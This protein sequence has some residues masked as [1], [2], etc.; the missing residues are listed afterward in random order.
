M[1]LEQ[2]LWNWKVIWNLDVDVVSSFVLYFDHFEAFTVTAHSFAF[3]LLVVY[4]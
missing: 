1:N 3:S 2:V 4:S